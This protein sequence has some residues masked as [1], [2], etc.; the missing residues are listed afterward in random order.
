MEEN[1]PLAE[2]ASQQLISFIVNNNLSAGDK[3]PNEFELA[4]LIGVG[5]ST[6]R[7]A[8]KVLASRH[9]LEVRQGAGTFI[10]EERLG[11]SEDPLG[12]TFIK[13]K[14]KLTL[15]LLDMRITIE[16]RIAAQAAMNA[17]KEDIEK[18]WAAATDV[19]ELINADIDH[20]QKD[21]EFHRLI[22]ESSKNLVVPKLMPIIQQAISLFVTTTSRVLKQET[23]DTHRAIIKG[24]EKRDPIAASDAMTLHLIYNRNR[25]HRLFEEENDLINVRG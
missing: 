13:D 7:E 6:I 21:I 10:T 2:V 4:D 20:M 8:V 19:E 24:I 5:R 18:M 1:R 16:P 15:D 3:L 25:I 11:V 17:T 12:F 14:K 22:A 9:I 23:I